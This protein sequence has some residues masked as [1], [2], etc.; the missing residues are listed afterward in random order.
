MRM[1]PTHQSRLAKGGA[2]KFECTSNDDTAMKMAALRVSVANGMKVAEPSA[3]HLCSFHQTDSE[4][5][6]LLGAFLAVGFN[7]QEKVI[8]IADQHSTRSIL[9]KLES[10]GIRLQHYLATGQM[11]VFTVFQSFLRQGVFDPSTMI[12]WLQTELMRAK[13]EGYRGLSVAADMTWALRGA[14]GSE[15]L[16][17][18]EAGLNNTLDGGECRILCQYDSHRFSPAVL[19]YVLTSHPAVVV[20]TVV[21]PNS[22]FRISPSC[23]GESSASARINAWLADLGGRNQA[24]ML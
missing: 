14:A 15:R 12:T 20:G 6:E 9:S 21:C 19:Q 16:I 4:R 1:Q 3:S 8:H 23:F 18:Y 5:S 13:A 22:Y 2:V 17:E 24:V 11:R 7:R 10:D